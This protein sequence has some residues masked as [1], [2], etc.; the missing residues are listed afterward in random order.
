MPLLLRALRTTLS[1]AFAHIALSIISSTVEAGVVE[2]DS[3]TVT[4]RRF[5]ESKAE[6]PA[7]IKVITREAFERRP[8]QTLID[9]LRTEANLH[10]KSFSGNAAQSEVSLRGFGANINSRVLVLVDGQKLNRPDIGG[11]NWLQIPLANV[12]RVEVI[13]GA[14]TAYYG[15]HAVGGVIKITTRGG[16]EKGAGTAAAILGSHGTAI[17]RVGYTGK[18]DDF[19][20][21]LNFEYNRSDGYRT[22][23]DYETK[24]G[25]FKLHHVI[26]NHTTLHFGGSWTESENGFPGALG[27][28]DAADDRRQSNTPNDRGRG[29]YG[30]IFGG[31]NL[32]WADR[33]HIEI[34]AGYNRRDLE[35]DFSFSI[36]DNVIESFSFSPKYRLDGGAGRLTIGADAVWDTLRV[37]RFAS[38]SRESLLGAAVL[39]RETAGGYTLYSRKVGSHWDL[40]SGFRLEQTAI[41]AK[42][43]DLDFVDP[44]PANPISSFE[45]RKSEF[46]AAFNLGVVYKIS[47]ESRVYFRFDRLYRYPATDE[48]AAYQGFP[49]AS[50]FNGDLRAETGYNIEGGFA[51]GGEQWE[52][53]VGFFAQWLDGEIDFD[54]AEFLNVNLWNTR[55]LGLETSLEYRPNWGRVRLDYSYVNAEFIEG[56]F[57][58]N[59]LF[60]VPAHRFSIRGEIVLTEALSAGAGYSYTSS[61]VEGSDYGNSQSRLPGYHLVDLYARLK[62]SEAVE[63]FATV[64]NLFEEEYAS[65]SFFGFSY[66]APLRAISVGVS[67]RF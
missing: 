58:G 19:N 10:I 54:F 8:A 47:E 20:Y 26:D 30:V 45:D 23:S 38:A 61:M 22:N 27:P 64:D 57:R 65:L 14:Q 52:I 43:Y 39:N 37:D 67:V 59:E 3:Y 13:K 53:G 34:T 17:G 24:S 11:H 36:S 42:S 16:T 31:I 1:G 6:V 7:N 2:L 50:P 9:V 21:A 28:S 12:E 35:S 40:S 63:C 44:D 55:R 62:V 32:D 5:P 41:S 33:R 49:L 29:E 51:S 48:I 60:L 25:G 15:N 4:A 46:A 56:T 18:S 66:P